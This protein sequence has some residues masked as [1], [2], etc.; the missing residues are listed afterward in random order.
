MHIHLDVASGVPIYAQLVQQVRYLI[1]AGRLRPGEEMPPIRVLAERLVINPNTVARAYRDLQ[2]C[3]LVVKRS[4][5]GTFVAADAGSRAASD[6]LAALAPPADALVAAARRHRVELD[7]VL[8]IVR[9]R[10]RST[11]EENGEAE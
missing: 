10:Y 6:A 8:E 11:S 7:G 3:G 1:A 5:T 4:T 2:Q 9:R